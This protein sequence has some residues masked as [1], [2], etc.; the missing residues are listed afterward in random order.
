MYSARYAYKESMRYWELD[1]A[2]AKVQSRNLKVSQLNFLSNNM[3]V[4]GNMRHNVQ[5][6]VKLLI[7]S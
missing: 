7:G 1:F 3:L 6:R 4:S 5:T 2:V